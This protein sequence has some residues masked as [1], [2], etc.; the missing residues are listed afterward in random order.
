MAALAPNPGAH[1]GF[2]REA[3]ARPP[4]G[5][6]PAVRAVCRRTAGG[7]RCR[8]RRLPPAAAL[9]RAARAVRC[10]RHGSASRDLPHL[11]H[12]GAAAPAAVYGR[13]PALVPVDA[14][15]GPR[16]DS[17]W[18]SSTRRPNVRRLTRDVR[19]ALDARPA[20]ERSDRRRAVLYLHHHARTQLRGVVA[21]LRRVPAARGMRRRATTDSVAQAFRP[22]SSTPPAA[23]AGP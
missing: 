21:A 1:A 16:R 18:H 12:A 7:A 5:R 11:G 20:R 4:R 6:R 22:A 23:G 13:Q 17:P 19:R 2:A 3:R 9:H 10:G 14:G 15:H 8:H